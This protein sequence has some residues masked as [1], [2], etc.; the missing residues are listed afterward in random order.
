MMSEPLIITPFPTKGAAGYT[1]ET[2]AAMAADFA[3]LNLE[4]LEHYFTP[5]PVDHVVLSDPQ[6]HI[7]DK[8]GE[9]YFAQTADGD[10][11][12]AVSLKHQGDGLYELSK[13][14]V[15]ADTRGMGAGRMMVRAVID[16]FQQLGGKRLY[17]E[18]NDALRPAIWLYENHGFRHQP[19]AF[20]SDFDRANVYMVWQ[21]SLPDS[22]E[23]AS[24]LHIQPADSTSEIATVKEF[25]TNYAQWLEATHGLSLAFQDFEV[26]MASFPDKYRCLLLAYSGKTAIGAVALLHHSDQQ[27]EM[28][29]LWVDPAAQR[30]GAGRALSICLMNKAQTFGYK[31]MLLDSLRRLTPAV[32]LYDSLGFQP[33]APYNHNPDPDVVYMQRKL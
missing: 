4:W 28:K 2:A 31:S 20:A 11:V 26:E 32:A 17:L 12:G 8:G 13:M 33:C 1:P 27:C 29:R 25:F 24:G 9:I 14:G 3:A 22:Q 21:G 30:S 7:L 10:R 18:S 23:K 15:R 16:R 6:Q 19:R 5:E